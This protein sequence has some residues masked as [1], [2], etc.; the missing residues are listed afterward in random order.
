MVI[1]FSQECQ[2]VFNLNNGNASTN[3]QTLPGAQLQRKDHGTGWLLRYPPTGLQPL[4]AMAAA[5]GQRH[6]AWLR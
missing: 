2:K 6:P 4:A 1:L 5:K 3:P